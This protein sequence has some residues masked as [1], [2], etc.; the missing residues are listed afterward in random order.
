MNPKCSAFPAGIP[1]EIVLSKADHRQPFPGD[2]GIQF[3][4]K[5]E[6]DGKYAAMIFDSPEA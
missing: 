4:P 6:A 2:K 1:D 3:E 5:T